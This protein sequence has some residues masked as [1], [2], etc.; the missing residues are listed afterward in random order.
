[1]IIAIMNTKGEVGKTTTRST[2]RQVSPPGIV[3]RL[4][5]TWIPR[6][7]QHDASWRVNQKG[8]SVT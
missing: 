5:S 7:T 2:W 6:P 4:S 8:I 1:M 3:E